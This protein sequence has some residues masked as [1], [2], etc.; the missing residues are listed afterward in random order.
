MAGDK[1]LTEG[2]RN[3]A[4]KGV[5]LAKAVSELREASKLFPLA[6]SMIE[7]LN[8]AKEAAVEEI[9]DDN[10]AL[11]AKLTG[12]N[13]KAASIEINAGRA[14]T[15]A[16]RVAAAEE[17]LLETGRTLEEKATA[18]ETSAASASASAEEVKT[19]IST[20]K[21]KVGDKEYSGTQA[22]S[23]LAKLV[24]NVPA[25]VKAEVERVVTADVKLDD[26]N[27]QKLSGA[28]LTAYLVRELGIVSSAAG[29]AVAD[30]EHVEQLLEQ[31]GEMVT[32]SNDAAIKAE[33]QAAEAKT[34][35]EE[36][37]KSAGLVAELKGK[38]A[39][40]EKNLKVMYGVVMAVLRNNNLNTD[41][42][43]EM[44]AEA[45]EE[46]NASMEGEE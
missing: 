19:A 4:Q 45:E 27:T 43:E 46:A 12:L 39:E 40:A 30:A 3:G 23:V 29:R 2:N 14:A 10:N 35:A 26:G 33:Q 44:V 5:R 34:A 28:E 11:R 6:T 21:I 17:S 16:E 1:V 41:V 9:Q 24:T 38:L 25:T 18:A 36:A 13:E 31:G 32:A 15:A 20:L 8:G 37:T 7:G 22:L 42:T